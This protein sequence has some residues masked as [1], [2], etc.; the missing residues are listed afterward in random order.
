[1]VRS[2]LGK[3]A[4]VGRTASMVFGL[5]LVLAL[6]VGL[7]DAALGANGQA[8]ILGRVNQATTTT[9][10]NASV[11]GKAALLVANPNK[12]PASRAL[13]L[14]VAQGKAP[15]AVNSDT[16][17]RNLNADKLDGHE[18]PMWAVVDFQGNLRRTSGALSSAKSGTGFY[19]V[20]F[21]RDVRNCAY[22][23][24][25]GSHLGG[26][27]EPDGKAQVTHYEFATNRVLVDTEN[28]S[29]TDTDLGFHLVV[30]C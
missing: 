9:Q 16:R 12:A 18:A 15:M 7:A 24:T 2:A 6:V 28:L 1:M 25:I 20:D 30:N 26:S 27:F 13:H 3:V 4:W 5:A 10:L 17:V 29:G 8:W 11:A 21:V 14:N 22:T 23:A 19:Q